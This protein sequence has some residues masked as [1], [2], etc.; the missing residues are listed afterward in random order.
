MSKRNGTIVA[1]VALTLMITGICVGG[2][3]ET[4]LRNVVGVLVTAAVLFHATF[5][6][7][8]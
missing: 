7:N 4:V 1:L 8:R 3:T 6:S 2:E 5:R